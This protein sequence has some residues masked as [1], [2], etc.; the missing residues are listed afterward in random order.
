MSSAGERRKLWALRAA[1]LAPLAAGIAAWFAVPEFRE[2]CT[3]GFA[4]LRAADVEGLRALGRELGAAAALFTTLLMIV[5]AIAAPLPAVVVTAANSLLF[6]PFAGA[7]LSIAS[8]TLAALLCFA[9]ARAW[10][11]PIVARLVAPA[12]LARA[13]AF[14]DEHGALAVLA[15]RLFP[16]VPF[17]PISYVA[18]LSRMRATTFAWTTLVGQIPAGLAY[19]YLA[20]RIDRPRQLALLGGLTLLGLTVAGWLARRVL[21]ATRERAARAK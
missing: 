9:L 14:V 13:N 17:D 19:S 16:F 21:L 6:G 1:S 10:G 15:A 12:R 4:L 5:Q 18:G 2:V 11:E 3:R 8:A 20:Q 7:C